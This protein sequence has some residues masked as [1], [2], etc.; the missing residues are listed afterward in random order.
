M[1][2]KYQLTSKRVIPEVPR[3]DPHRLTESLRRRLMSVARTDGDFSTTIPGLSVHRRDHT[4]EAIPCIYDLG[5]AVTVAGTKEVLAG[6]ERFEYG[7][8]EALFASVDMPVTSRVLSATPA[9]PYLGMMLRL[10][11]R[12][13]LKV[14]SGLSIP[15]GRPGVSNSALTLG[16]LGAEVV[17]ALERLVVLLDAPELLATVAPLIIQE[18]IARLLISP[19]GPQFMHL[20]AGGT[21]RSQVAQC[22]AWLKQHFDESI[23]I[24]ALAEQ[25]HMSPS[26]FR[27]HFKSVSGMSPLQYIKQLRLLEA[28]QLMLN[29]GLDAGTSG[30][31]VGYES[32]SQF[33]REYARL[34]GTPPSRDMRRYRSMTQ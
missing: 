30:L 34:F 13:V 29:D 15:R 18:I 23:S 32:V 14:A 25:A 19:H 2:M 21:P 27:A 8:G 26:T 10:E 28:R 16:A 12:L 5:L 22:M 9:S 24:D 3:T 11:P 7:A 6:N 20:N 4:T 17:D 31:R 33:S 1:L